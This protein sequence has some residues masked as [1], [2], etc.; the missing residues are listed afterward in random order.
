MTDSYPRFNIQGCHV[1]C[2]NHD[3]ALKAVAE[4]LEQAIGGYVCFSNV[5]TVVT[6]HADRALRDNTN[7]S[8]LSLPDGRPL[9]VYAK[10][11]GIK[12]VSQVAGPDFMGKC[13]AKFTGKRHYFYGA[14]EKTLSLLKANLLRNYPGLSIVGMYSPPFRPLS[15][16]E[17]SEV[18]QKIRNAE[19]DFVWVGLGAPK[20]EEWMGQNWQTLSPAILFGV[21]AAFD[22][23]A[24]T[25][26]RAPLWMRELGLEWLYRL[27]KEPR[28]LWKRYLVTNTVFLWRLSRDW[29]TRVR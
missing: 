7:N 13:L 8:F 3:S 10:L 29:V 18:T 24:G 14:T 28:R 2:M 23:Y 19:P 20:Q 9:S 22:F 12:D 5:H 6:S 16:E 26:L 17:L 1:N 27:F 15:E 25:V 21:G 4:R 11:I